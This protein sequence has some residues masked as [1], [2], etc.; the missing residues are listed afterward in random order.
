MKIVKK[1]PIKNS[2]TEQAP[3]IYRENFKYLF[4]FFSNG[5]ISYSLFGLLIY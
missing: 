2:K 5:K 3:N 1:I 4:V